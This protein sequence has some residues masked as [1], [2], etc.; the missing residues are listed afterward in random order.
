M[1]DALTNVCREIGYYSH[2]KQ[3]YGVIQGGRL[4][5]QK[6]HHL[7]QAYSTGLLPNQKKVNKAKELNFLFTKNGQEQGQLHLILNIP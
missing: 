5:G 7:R 4:A 1:M 3:K 6:L 2:C